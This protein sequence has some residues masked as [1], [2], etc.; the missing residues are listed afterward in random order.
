[1]AANR[2]PNSRAA[3]LNIPYDAEFVDLFLAYIAGLAAHGLTPRATL[4][5]PGGTRRLD[6]IIELIQSCRYSF[7]DLSRV[8]LDASAPPTPRFNMPF[9]LGLAVAC[10]RLVPNHHTWFVMESENRRLLKSLSDLGGT[11]VYIHDG[12]L[13]GVFREI[14]N[15]LVRSTR[16]P[17]VKDLQVIHESLRA[18]MPEILNRTGAKSVYEARSFKQLVVEASALA[19]N[20]MR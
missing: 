6:R 16:Q 13:P 18:V 12:N 1:M 9:E 2:R 7:H 4:E 20:Q 14:G 5:V 19:N 11:D 3:F 10:D 17:S 8:E 15:A